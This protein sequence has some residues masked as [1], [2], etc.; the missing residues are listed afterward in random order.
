MSHVDMIWLWLQDSLSSAAHHDE[1]QISTV[2]AEYGV[3]PGRNGWLDYFKHQG[4]AL[5]PAHTAA[6]RFYKHHMPFINQQ[7][8]SM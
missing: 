5:S 3:R 4:E 2:A 1:I 7:P 6:T 8:S